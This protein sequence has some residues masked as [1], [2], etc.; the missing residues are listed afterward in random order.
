[1]N[2]FAANQMA[3][4]IVRLKINWFQLPEY[5]PPGRPRK[6]ME[7]TKVAKMDIPTTQVG[8]L[9]SALVKAEAPELLLRKKLQPKSTTAARKAKK[10][11]KSMK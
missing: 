11:I 6:L 5:D 7:L 4:G 9:P 1:M 10:T 2:I 8:T 3:R